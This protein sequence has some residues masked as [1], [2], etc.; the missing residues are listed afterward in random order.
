MKRLLIAFFLLLL[1]QGAPAVQP[2]EVLDDSALEARAR[3]ITGELRCVVCQSESIDDSNADIARDL[4]ILVRERLTAGDTDA[5]AVDF[6]V[7]RYGEYVLM[8]PPFTSA[9]AVLWLS[10]PLFLLLGGGIAFAY[11]RGRSSAAPHPIVPL[12]ESERER[13]E[14]IRA[15]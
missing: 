4:R 13:L 15:D 1:P 3:E 10:G 9:N 2:D 7:D 6:I 14:R 12:S 5:Q 8:R 11:V